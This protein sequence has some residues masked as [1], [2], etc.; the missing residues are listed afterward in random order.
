MKP[1]CGGPSVNE[2][3]C[4]IPRGTWLPTRF[5]RVERP[6]L[7]STQPLQVRTAEGMA[8]LKCSDS[9]EGSPAL[10]AEFIGSCLADLVGLDTFDFGLVDFGLSLVTVEEQQRNLSGTSFVARWVKGDGWSASIEE[11]HELSNR[12]DVTKLILVDTW[13]RNIDRHFPPHTRPDNIFIELDGPESRMIAMDFTHAMLIRNVLNGRP[14]PNIKDPTVFGRFAV[15]D[16]YVTPTLI[17]ESIASLR[18]IQGNAIRDI[19]GSIPDDWNV[20]NHAKLALTQA[21]LDRK[22]YL[23]GTFQGAMG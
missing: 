18:S 12:T 16:Q 19:V 1:R 5:E 13:L 14:P 8:I 6:I 2:G 17:A 21:I 7:S 3:R 10:V 23:E 15:L 20:L 4:S 22:S 11:W 9:P